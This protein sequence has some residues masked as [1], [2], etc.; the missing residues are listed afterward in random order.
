MKKIKVLGTLLTS[1]L[2]GTGPA[3]GQAAEAPP[4]EPAAGNS[5]HVN[6]VGHLGIGYLGRR[7]MQIADP[8]SP[9]GA[10]TPVDAPVIGVRYWFN[11]ML[12]IDAGLGL[13][14]TGGSVTPTGGDEIDKVGSTIFILHS[15]VPLAPASTDHCSFQVVPELNLGFASASE[16]LAPAPDNELSGFNLDVGARAG[17]EIHYGFIVIPQLALQAGV[18]LAFAMDRV[19]ASNPGGDDPAEEAKD[20]TTTFGTTVAGNPW[21]I[22]TGNISALYYF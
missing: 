11:P 9:V 2:L 13:S 20:S 21:D 1:A 6:V 16:T 4:A 15:G 7:S 5:D 18:G 22:F 12:G 3:W 8:G 19:S 14:F 17:A 10:P